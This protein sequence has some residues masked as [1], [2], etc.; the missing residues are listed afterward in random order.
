MDL[1]EI[2]MCCPAVYAVSDRYIITVPVTEPCVMW[3]RVGDRNYYDHSNGILRSASLTHMMEVPSAAL[4]SSRSYT[5]CWRKIIERKPYFSDLCDVSEW[6]S[7]FRPCGTRDAG[8]INIYHIA[9]AHNRV[10]G[11]IAAGS[12]FGDE[13]DLLILNGDIPN[14]S[15]DI[16]NFSAI[17]RIAGT[18]SGGTVPVIFSRGNHDM[19][20]IYAEELE[21]HTPTD[22]GRS[23]FTVK[24]G[25]VWAVVLD[26][27]ED[28]P[29]GNPEYGH[30]ICC[31]EFREEETGFLRGLEA[32]CETEYAA[33]G[34][35]Y[36]LV[37]AHNPFCEPRNA[38][39]DIEMDRYAEWASILKKTVKP[40][41]MICGHTHRCY[42][43]MP[44]DPLDKL[45]QP[46]PVIAASALSKEDREYYRGGAITLE[47][48]TASVSFT[49]SRGDSSEP[50]TV[51]LGDSGI[52]VKKV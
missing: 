9:D 15:G 35:E 21:R 5:V 10:S 27:A 49:D 19:R 12:R 30:T 29:D 36:R 33:P 8:K 41:L 1:P 37:I 48:R 25:R 11:P 23:Y 43:T 46:C 40:D 44:G 13:L 38:P 32:S 47:G 4:D 45:G 52:P 3:V 18:V 16:K 24:L 34:V 20:G 6:S 22:R 28:K 26:C 51:A 17:H 31:A 39:F 42:V 2:F 7:S 14:H 50:V